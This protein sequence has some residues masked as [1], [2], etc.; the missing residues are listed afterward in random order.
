M[1]FPCH[2]PLRQRAKRFFN[3][4]RE[5]L[6]LMTA[7]HDEREVQSVSQDLWQTV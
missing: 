1:P 7:R 3:K 5:F 2:H 4:R 6:M